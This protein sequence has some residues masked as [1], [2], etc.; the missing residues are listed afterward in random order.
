[1]GPSVATIICHRG[2][3]C[4]AFFL[5]APPVLNATPNDIGAWYG[6]D[7]GTRW[8]IPFLSSA[9]RRITEDNG[10][11]AER[12]GRNLSQVQTQF[13]SLCRPECGVRAS[14]LG[15]RPG[16]RPC[17]WPSDRRGP[18]SKCRAMTFGSWVVYEF[19]E[20]TLVS[21]SASFGLFRV[22]WIARRGGAK[23]ARQRGARSSLMWLPWTALSG[24]IRRH[25]QNRTSILRLSKC[26]RNLDHLAR[27]DPFQRVEDCIG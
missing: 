6:L 22:P 2:Q 21:R 23:G 25:L 11:L 3:H 26:W 24:L 18:L 14:A 8:T 17:R 12:D 7:S 15:F 10:L 5:C 16:L 27:L 20:N 4:A 13:R 9:T 19:R 1:M